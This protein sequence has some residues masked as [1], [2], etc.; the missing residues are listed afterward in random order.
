[1]GLQLRLV[2]GF[3]TLALWCAAD[4]AHANFP[5]FM[6]CDP[7]PTEEETQA[8]SVT[9]TEQTFCDH[10][11]QI[12]WRACAQATLEQLT[13]SDP[14]LKHAPANVVIIDHHDANAF[15]LN[16]RSI[17]LTSS[18]LEQLE[19]ASDLSFVI[20]HELGHFHLNHRTNPP[21][22][23]TGRKELNGG[24]LGDE[25][26]AD[27]YALWLTG[28]SANV[29]HNLLIRLTKN[30]SLRSNLS[31]WQQIGLITRAENLRKTS[32]YNYQP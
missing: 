26:N 23:E 3:L 8:I 12:N 9:P 16:S 17:A 29:P 1:M 20:G 19:G 24:H 27:A 21:F 15:L 5:A 11:P 31:S 7:Q 4:V 2:S 13:Q 25:L 14:S 6:Q 18:L 22:K 10:L 28:Q 30:Q 32:S